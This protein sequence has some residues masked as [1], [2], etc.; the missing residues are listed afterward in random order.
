MSRTPR[1]SSRL[2]MLAL[3]TAAGVALLA[4]PS[5]AQTVEELTITGHLGD[6]AQLSQ[7]VNYA[8]LDLTTKAG[9]DM[10][11][12]R[13][14][15]T[16]KD[17]CRRLGEANQS[18]TPLVPSCEDGA[19]RDAMPQIRQ[20]VAMATPGMG[21]PAMSMTPAPAA[22]APPSASEAAPPPAVDVAATVP[23]PTYTV[24]TLTNGPV[25]DTAET[26]RMYGGPMSNAGR[27]T[28]PSGD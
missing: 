10:L 26:R 27:R 4:G 13:I 7:A 21:A 11:K 16:A 17:L 23:A 25:P 3:M 8:D 14:K 18:S 28:A 5:N 22:Y 15:D 12:T 1:D 9:E 24:K 2:T 20:A 19:Y 6:V